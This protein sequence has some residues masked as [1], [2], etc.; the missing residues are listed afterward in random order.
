MWAYPNPFNPETTIGFRL[1]RAEMVRLTVYDAAG[2]VVRNL[3]QR[4][5]SAGI[6]TVR[7]APTDE[8][9][10]GLA[11]GV[12]FYRLETPSVKATRKL[13]LLK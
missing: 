1:D 7:F 10:I 8:A 13:V 6:H 11:S 5:M 9:G 3:L 2:R 12:Y 4:G